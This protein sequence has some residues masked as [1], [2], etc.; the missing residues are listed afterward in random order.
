[1][2]KCV[3]ENGAPNNAGGGS[4][5]CHQCQ[6]MLGGGIKSPM[7]ANAR[8]HDPANEG[9][10]GPAEGAAPLENVFERPELQIVIR[11][12]GDFCTRCTSLHG[13]SMEMPQ[14]SHGEP[15]DGVPQES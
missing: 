10:L 2:N 15:M 8:E 6:D 12:K 5:L 9:Q 11:Y 13:L 14:H 1:M 7:P 3:R 4:A